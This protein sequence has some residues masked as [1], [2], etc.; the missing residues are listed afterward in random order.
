MVSFSL[1]ALKYVIN[2][3]TARGLTDSEVIE[4]CKTPNR[5]EKERLILRKRY[6]PVRHD[7]FKK[8]HKNRKLETLLGERPPTTDSNTSTIDS[9]AGELIKS[10]Y[11]HRKSLAGIERPASEVINSNLEEFF[12]D[13]SKDE[14]EIVKRNSRLGGKRMFTWRK[15]AAE[16]ECIPEVT[17]EALGGSDIKRGDT[18]IPPST[19]L[20]AAATMT[21]GTFTNTVFTAN[22]DLGDLDHSAYSSDMKWMK[23]AF[24]G[25]GSFGSVYLGL[26]TQ[27]GEMFAAKQVELDKGSDESK[28]SKVFFLADW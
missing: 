21:E 27:T 7:E 9:K 5:P 26:N 16:S 13:S 1:L 8:K 23:G 12:P 20:M 10:N 2:L 22:A 6:Q 28:E 19:P 15:E 14:L 17:E 24:L 3:R 18:L 4:I 25:A 11:A